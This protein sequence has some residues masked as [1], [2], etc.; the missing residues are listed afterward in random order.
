VL[1][2]IKTRKIVTVLLNTEEDRRRI[3]QF[4]ELF[5]PR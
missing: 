4:N 5:K 3:K 1:D 2:T